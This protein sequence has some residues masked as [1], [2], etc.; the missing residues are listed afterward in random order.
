[1]VRAQVVAL[2]TRTGE[3]GAMSWKEVT[4]V[5]SATKGP[6]NTSVQSR[7]DW[8]AGK[9]MEEDDDDDE[10]WAGKKEEED[11]VDGMWMCILY[12]WVCIYMFSRFPYV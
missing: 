4:Q 2:D 1:M 12:T 10:D 6:F 3:G 8:A 5:K 11:D 7:A 9:E